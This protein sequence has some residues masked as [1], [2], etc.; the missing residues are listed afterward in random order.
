VGAAALA[1]NTARASTE[2]RWLHIRVEE[3]GGDG[4][5]V[6]VNLPLSMIESVAPLLDDVQVDGGKMRVND[7]DLDAAQLRKFLEAVKNSP[8]GEYVTVDSID[9]RVRVA[10]SGPLFLI[11]AQDEREDSRVDV[12]IPIAVVDALLSAPDGKLNLSEAVKALGDRATGDL[13]TIDE[14]DSHVRIWIDERNESK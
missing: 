10:K 5:N 1:A 4:E 2:T 6:R 9:Q 11:H 3:R 8:D 12:K 14:R 7:Q 13:I